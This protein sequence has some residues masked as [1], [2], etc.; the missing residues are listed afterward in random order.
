MTYTTEA[1]TDKPTVWKVLWIS[2]GDGA[3]SKK[4]NS[5]GSDLS[6]NRSSRRGECG[7]SNDGMCLW[8]PMFC[9]GCCG[10]DDWVVY[11]AE[12]PVPTVFEKLFFEKV[13]RLI[14]YTCDYNPEYSVEAFYWDWASFRKN[15]LLPNRMH[16]RSC[17]QLSDTVNIADQVVYSAISCFMNGRRGPPKPGFIL[18]SVEDLDF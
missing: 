3:F 4:N 9:I 8:F 6:F 11:V 1:K 2:F 14:Q 5:H 12:I 13:A 17:M 15:I 18:F 10:E 7:L 16:I